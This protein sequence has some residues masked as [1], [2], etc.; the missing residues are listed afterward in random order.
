MCILF[1]NIVCKRNESKSTQ[2]IASRIRINSRLRYKISLDHPHCALPLCAH[3]VVGRDVNGVSGR[4][5]AHSQAQVRNTAGSVLLHQNVLGLQVPVS[6]GW[7]TC[8]PR[9]VRGKRHYWDA[10]NQCNEESNV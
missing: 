8:K 1:K 5:M 9:P 6:D 4:V 3:T 7:F 2:L 10:N